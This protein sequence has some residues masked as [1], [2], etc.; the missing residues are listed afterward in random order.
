MQLLGEDINLQGGVHA[1]S[2]SDFDDEL[3]PVLESNRSSDFLSLSLNQVA[4]T[5]PRFQGSMLW[6]FQNNFYSCT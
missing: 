2:I 6:K 4:K 1:L 5:S 3:V